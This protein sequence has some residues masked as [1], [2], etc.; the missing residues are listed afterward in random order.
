MDTL[1]SRDWVE[2]K[3]DQDEMVHGKEVALQLR[4]T[5]KGGIPWSVIFDVTGDELETLVTSDSPTAGNIGCPM[6]P[7][8]REWMVEMLR[9]TRTRTKDAEL[10]RF[11]G[12]LAVFAKR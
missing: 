10:E 1:I 4:G 12:W 6:K 5:A 8:E 11:A 2:L 9:R 7:A 3:I